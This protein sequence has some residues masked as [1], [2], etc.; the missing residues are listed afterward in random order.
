MTLE[1]CEQLV[2]I[3][4]E[5]FNVVEANRTGG[6]RPAIEERELAEDVARCAYGQNDL[7]S[8][9]VLDEQLDV[10]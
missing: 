1:K 7:G 10:A 4:L 2:A 3:E 6:S 5:Q 8:G 9:V